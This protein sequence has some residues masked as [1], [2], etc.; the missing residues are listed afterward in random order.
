MA[1]LIEDPQRATL[2][3]LIGDALATTGR[4]QTHS[5]G[6]S[7]DQATASMWIA[8]SPVSV[9][10]R[11]YCLP[12]AGGVS[13]N[14]FARYTLIMSHCNLCTTSCCLELISYLTFH[15]LSF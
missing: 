7:A 8:R 4:T 11:L 2:E 14:V 12:Y 5:A 9:K 1:V 3:Q 15:S 6:K 10:L 13:E